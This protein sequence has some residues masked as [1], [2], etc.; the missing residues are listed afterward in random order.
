MIEKSIADL[1]SHNGKGKRI[2]N[3]EINAKRE[4]DIA[5]VIFKD[6]INL[7]MIKVKVL[8]I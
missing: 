1:I 2:H 6:G 4:Q 5:H 3:A 7:R 8:W